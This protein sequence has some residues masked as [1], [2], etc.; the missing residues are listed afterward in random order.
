MK[1]YN[2][3]SRKT[4]PLS[5][6][7]GNKEISMYVCGPTVYDL[8]HIGHL[9]SAFVF[10]S[11]R[12][13]WLHQE[14]SVRFVRNVTDVD[15]KIIDKAKE[16]LKAEGVSLSR[17]ALVEKCREVS[18]CYLR[19]YHEVLEKFHILPPTEE[20]LATDHVTPLMT[21]FI[22][23]LIDQGKAYASAGN[24]YFAVREQSD[25]GT[26]SHRTIDELQAGTRVEP[27]EGKRDPM[28]FAL[29]KK[30][31]PEEPAW[32]SPWGPGR[33]GWH[34]ECSAM[35]VSLLG[36]SFDI[37]GG[38]LDLIFPH[39]E[40]EMAQARGAGYSFARHWMHHGLVT[41]NG[42]KMSKSL[43]NFTTVEDTLKDCNENV[44]AVKTFFLGT[45]YRNPLDFTEE[46]L[47]AAAARVNSLLQFMDRAQRWKEGARLEAEMPEDIQTLR[48]E[49]YD[50]LAQDFNTPL[51]LSVLDKLANLGFEWETDLSGKKAAARRSH[52]RP[53]VQGK[54]LLTAAT[55]QELGK[56]LGLFQDYRPFEASGDQLEL[57]EK[58]AAA[59]KNREFDIADR[60]R[61]ELTGMGLSIEDT[62]HGSFLLPLR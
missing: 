33:P 10:D 48:S 21:D 24:V 58:R 6:S 53:V 43:G 62:P 20:P 19:A 1:F 26:L 55:I 22:A 49:F 5:E 18:Q 37:H 25:Y 57:L 40:N 8:P 36:Q 42:E 28:D 23:R 29:W 3:L 14:M 59:R 44:D 2:T 11:I 34:I 12:R 15:D 54:I 4:E 32:D 9:R 51:A 56:V 31:K 16:E 41:V 38:G 60:I 46:S 45:H 50:A 27:G 17:E 7:G 47:Q 30:S 13:Y 52:E 35:S 39:H 61:D